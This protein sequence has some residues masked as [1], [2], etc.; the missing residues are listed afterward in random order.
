VW[1]GR[2]AAD[3]SVRLQ[4]FSKTLLT[5]APSPRLIMR[6]HVPDAREV[7]QK[8]WFW[9]AQRFSAAIRTLFI[10]GF[11][12]WGQGFDFFGSAESDK[13]SH[14]HFFRSLLYSATLDKF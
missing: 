7:A 4:V 10:S 9:V 2:T 8:V 5:K 13:F 14:Y 1:H 11:S 6:R 3:K 12:R